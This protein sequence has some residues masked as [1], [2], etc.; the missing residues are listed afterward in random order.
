MTDNGNRIGLETD[1]IVNM[2]GNVS[3]E[4]YKYVQDVTTGS[5]EVSAQNSPAVLAI[6]ENDLL[7][8]TLT[9]QNTSSNDAY[10]MVVIDT[11]PFVGDTGVIDPRDRKSD[12]A[13]SFADEIKLEVCRK[14]GTPVAASDYEV[15][16][17]Y[18][19]QTAD[20]TARDWAGEDDAAW[21]AEPA[22]ANTIR[23]VFSAVLSGE[24]AFLI[25]FQ[26]QVDNSRQIVYT[27]DEMTAWNSFG[28]AY[29]ATSSSTEQI[30]SESYKVGVTLSA[31][32]NG[33][34]V[35]KLLVDDDGNTMDSTAYGSHAATEF[36]LYLLRSKDNITWDYVLGASYYIDDEN[37]IL[38]TDA[39]DGSFTIHPGETVTF[40]R[41]SGDYYYRVTEAP[42]QSMGYA[43]DRIRYQQGSLDIE[44][45]ALETLS[46]G[47]IAVA[48]Y[49]KVLYFSAMPDAG[50]TGIIGYWSVGCML[51]FCAGIGFAWKQI[52][53]RRKAGA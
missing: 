22:G 14:D 1:A 34:T 52:H 38:T 50:G 18:V 35:E 24:D 7:L 23:I 27:G 26:A 21:S 53:K 33:L 29:S 20:L 25:R 36:T 47:T 3:N 17:A 43:L 9:V 32:R 10:D 5:G 6:D 8:Y 19:T 4:A 46:A 15:S 45:R 31:V 11:L 37:T 49:N 40:T 48:V 12:F 39:T 2:T 30:N 42:P 16:Y 13:I 41:L 44:E 51:I 28:Y